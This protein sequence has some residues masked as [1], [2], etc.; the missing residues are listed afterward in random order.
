[1]ASFRPARMAQLV[2]RVPNE[3]RGAADYQLTLIKS[4][5]Y[6]C[7]MADNCIF[8][9]AKE[10]QYSITE[11]LFAEG[12]PSSIGLQC[13]GHL[14]IVREISRASSAASEIQ[15]AATEIL[16]AIQPLLLGKLPTTKRELARLQTDLNGL[17]ME[18]HGL[19]NQVELERRDRGIT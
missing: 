11:R 17:S 7:N 3:K 15:E 16:S 12:A 13:E 10:M 1:M 4:L 2:E 6:G 19:S 18:I 8:E 14:A 9:E 5:T